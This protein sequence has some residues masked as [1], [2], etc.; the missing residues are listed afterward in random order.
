ML[1]GA[2]QGQGGPKYFKKS[3]ECPRKKGFRGYSAPK[4]LGLHIRFGHWV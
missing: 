4:R 3:L 2:R 1:E